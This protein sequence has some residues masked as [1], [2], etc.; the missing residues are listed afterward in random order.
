MLRVIR[1][2]L[3]IAL[4]AL[5]AC[6][7]GDELDGSSWQA[8]ELGSRPSL[9]D[10]R[11]TV[12]FQDGEVSGSGGCNSYTGSYEASSGGAYGGA[13]TLSITNV[14]GTEMACE[15][16][17]MEQ[18]Q[19]FYDALLA[20]TSYRIAADGLELLDGDEVVARFTR[21]T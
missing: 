5:S 9:S 13:P 4:V 18:E 17:V 11:S 16:P 3:A 1:I 20:T 6:A 8:V 14:G 2:G 15:D 10:V 12:S 21:S 19:A 7:G